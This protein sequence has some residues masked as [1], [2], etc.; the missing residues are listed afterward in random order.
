MAWRYKG[1]ILLKI[2]KKSVRIITLSGY[3]SHSE[4]L[5]KQLNM[6]K[7]EDQLRLQELKF[8]FKY[9]P[10]YL[11]DWEFISNV[12]I[13]VLP[14]I[15]KGHGAAWGKRALLF[16]KLHFK[17]TFEREII[18]WGHIAQIVGNTSYVWNV[19]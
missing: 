7:I 2:Q 9:M 16:A 13:S 15:E 10:A 8:Y 19:T 3:S 1:P 12:N 5:F 18:F 17:G 14:R 6:L 11:V 4:P